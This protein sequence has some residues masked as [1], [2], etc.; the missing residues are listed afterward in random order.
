MILVLLL[1]YLGLLFLAIKFKFIK[2]TLFWKFP[3]YLGGVFT[4]CFIYSSAILGAQWLYP[5][6]TT[7]STNCPERGG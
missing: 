4:G 3:H 5:H 1:G 7:D 2:P 6:H